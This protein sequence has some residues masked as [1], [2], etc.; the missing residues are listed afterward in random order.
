MLLIR[1]LVGLYD[2]L[3]LAVVRMISLGVWHMPYSFRDIQGPLLASAQNTEYKTPS[4]FMSCVIGR[5]LSFYWEKSYQQICNCQKVCIPYNRMADHHWLSVLL[6][7]LNI[8]Q[9]SSLPFQLP[10]YFPRQ[11]R[12]LVISVL[13]LGCQF[14]GSGFKPQAGSLGI[15]LYCC[16]SYPH[17][18][19]VLAS[20][21][22]DT[23][24]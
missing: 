4:C 24:W 3:P 13:V 7:I 12:G 6:L 15:L 21:L 16:F 10:C 1:S 23:Y 2:Q 14:L 11:S 19:A 18:I 17:L 5:L 9:F 8:L 22:L 20:C